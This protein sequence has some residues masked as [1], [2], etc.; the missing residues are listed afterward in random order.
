MREKS[1]AAS[2]CRVGGISVYRPRLVWS[3]CASTGVAAVVCG[4]VTFPALCTIARGAWPLPAG[5]IGRFPGPAAC[6]PGS[7]AAVNG[8]DTPEVAGVFLRRSRA[9]DPISQSAGKPTDDAEREHTE[10]RRATGVYSIEGTGIDPG[11]D[12]HSNHL[13]S[14][15]R[16]VAST[17]E[18]ICE[19]LTRYTP[20]ASE[21]PNRSTAS[22]R[23]RPESVPLELMGSLCTRRPETSK[24]STDRIHGEGIVHRSSV[25]HRNGFGT[26]CRRLSAWRGDGTGASPGSPVAMTDVKVS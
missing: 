13:C 21:R 4:S 24:T 18:S 11:N 3:H 6:S 23:S 19:S 14:K 25:V 26:A 17:L 22:S 15:I 10:V 5:P 20:G 12:R 1:V 9:P 8:F 16:V 2:S 7:R